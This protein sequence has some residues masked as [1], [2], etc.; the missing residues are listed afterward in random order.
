[1]LS[2]SSARGVYIRTL[3]PSHTASECFAYCST[4]GRILVVTM[5]C[6]R[7]KLWS[8]SSPQSAPVYSAMIIVNIPCKVNVMVCSSFSSSSVSVRF[9]CCDFNPLKA[10]ISSV[11]CCLSQTAGSFEV[12]LVVASRPLARLGRSGCR[13]CGLHQGAVSNQMPPWKV[14]EPV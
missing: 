14:Q 11:Y 7:L 3:D 9:L 1:M 8:I 4:I 10:M 6:A 5:R 2:Q 13:S 12:L